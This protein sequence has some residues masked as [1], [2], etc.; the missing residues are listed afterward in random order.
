MNLVACNSVV[1]HGTPQSIEDYF[2]ESGRVGRSGDHAKSLIFWKPG[3]FPLKV[4]P[5]TR[6]KEMLEVRRYLDNK[7]ECRRKWL[8]DYF[9]QTC[10]KRSENPSTCCDVCEHVAL[11]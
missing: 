4:E 2:Q 7:P 8:L 10:A 3:D 6:G 9:D 11:H 1:H 5:I